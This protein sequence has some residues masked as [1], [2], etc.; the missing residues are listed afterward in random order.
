MGPAVM[1]SRYLLD[2]HALLWWVLDA[3]R[4][5]PT[6]HALIADQT[7][8]VYVS[9]ASAWEIATKHRLG[10]LEGG[11]LATA[12]VPTARADNLKI[13][14]IKAAHAQLA[15]GLVG[16]HG[17]PFDRMLMAQSLSTGMPLVSNDA[18]FDQYGVTR[19]W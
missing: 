12:F 16:A 6:A 5:S 19:V 7:N 13:L 8:E 10:K 14:S 3:P 15:G 4:L 2:T 17:D 1:R 11:P 9:A 18:V